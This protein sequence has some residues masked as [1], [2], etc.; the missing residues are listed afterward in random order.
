MLGS[1]ENIDRLLKEPQLESVDAVMT[2]LDCKKY[3]E[4]TLDAVYSDIPIKNLFVLDGGSKDGTI[5]ILKKYPRVDLEV[6]PELTHAK[7]MDILIHKVTTD[8][9]VFVD[10]AKIPSKGWFDTMMS[11]RE[12]GEFLNSKRI[13]HYEFEREDPTTT[14]LTKRAIGGPWLLK[15]TAVK[16]YN[17]DNEFNVRLFDVIL[18]QVIEEHGF[19]Y[20]VVPEAYHVLYLTDE[21]R[22]TSHPTLRGT[23]LIF[24]NPES[25]V[26]NE[27]GYKIRLS[28]NAKGVVKYLDP[29]KV[30]DCFLDDQWFLLL[31]T[32]DKEWIKKTNMKWYIALK[33]WKKKRYVKA[34]LRCMLYDYGKRIIGFIDSAFQKATNIASTDMIKAWSKLK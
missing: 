22:Y 25:K 10:N 17:V 4:R 30:K 31:N 24:R 6:R 15:T 2:T 34:K 27:E 9:C 12:R 11:H 23:G 29:E 8:W 21:E 28:E 26:W 16:H 13:I 19:K 3:L 1:Y 18:R 33:E 20:G 5:E 32:L 7:S 14:D